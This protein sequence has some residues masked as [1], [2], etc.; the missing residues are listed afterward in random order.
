M[1]TLVWVVVGAAE[2][3]VREKKSQLHKIECK[4][5]KRNKKNEK[6]ENEFVRV[7]SSVKHE[8]VVVNIYYNF[9]KEKEKEL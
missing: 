9:L 3:R 7:F 6:R 8:R 4:K 2:T 1:A 5:E